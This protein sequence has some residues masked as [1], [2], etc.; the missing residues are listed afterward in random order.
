MSR[1]SQ[2]PGKKFRVWSPPE[3]P[4]RIE[5]LPGLFQE[6]LEAGSGT[7]YGHIAEKTIRITSA[8]G[9]GSAL[10]IFSAR[11][12]GEIFLTEDD[13]ERFESKDAKVAL[14]I[15]SGRAGF[16]VRQAD[17]SIQSIRS[18]QE[19]A[20]PNPERRRWT[21]LPAAALSL[22]VVALTAAW[23]LRQPPLAIS[24]REDAGQLRILFTRSN[25]LIEI[26]DGSTARSVPVNRSTTSLTY[27]PQSAD[28]QIRLT[29]GRRVETARYVAAD[30]I[31]QL[32][33]QIDSL[34][35]E[36]IVLAA[37]SEQNRQRAADLQRTL[38]KMNRAD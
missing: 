6:A 28:V 33:A 10:G 34:E 4:V 7:L 37:E 3:S 24:I 5:Y 15:A 18:H 19:V 21:R 27:A 25:G 17:G 29:S 14:V 31:A 26:T 35:T 38:S 9:G 8:N 1:F 22:V 16:F 11:D 12:R 23:A 36:A 2:V 30:R 32:R 13:L 20:A